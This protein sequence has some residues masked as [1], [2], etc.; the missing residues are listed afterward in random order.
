MF[1]IAGQ[2]IPLLINTPPVVLSGSFCSVN[3][4]PKFWQKLALLNPV[5]YL[6]SGFRW[7]FFE[8]SDVSV[9]LS[10][11]M[12]AGFLIGCLVVVWAMF[13]SGYKLKQ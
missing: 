2:P 4:L 8:V 5:L 11:F 7:S 13:N 10:L 3:M 6:I 9:T 1:I 12:I